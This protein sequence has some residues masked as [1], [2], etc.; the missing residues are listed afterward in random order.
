MDTNFSDAIVK[1]ALKP[2]T[3]RSDLKGI[4]HLAGH[5]AFLAAAAW[6]VAL[7]T[8]SFWLILTW[9]VYGVMLV[10]LFAPLHETIH[11]TAFKTRWL[12][13][14]VAW[15]CGAVLILPPAYFR[16]F[17]FAHHRFT[18]DPDRDPELL[19]AKPAS[20]G[21]YLRHASGLV[22]WRA[23]IPGL[24]RHAAGRVEE[25][26]IAPKQRRAIVVEARYYLGFYLGL[27]VA[28]LAFE[29]W[30]A[31]VYWIVPI[32]VAQPTLRLYLLAEHMGCPLVPDMFRNTRTTRTTWA[33]RALAW[34]MPF[35]VEHHAYPG[36]P[37]HALPATHQEL[38]DRIAV[39]APG[40]LA[41]HRKII[42]GLIGP[43]KR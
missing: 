36:I 12:N 29:T 42:A 1:G 40:Y 27:A 22:Y 24:L 33:L 26:F 8:G 2:L 38:K 9:P 32:V 19:S 3:R 10:F 41:V 14:L 31:V 7:S 37:F 25:T 23:Q 18:Q 11:R 43:G 4:S 15:M 16:A 17:H 5:L 34:N 28:S 39:P 30:A 35:H 13:D 6:L 20:L 21:A